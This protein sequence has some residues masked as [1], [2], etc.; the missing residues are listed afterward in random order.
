MCVHMYQ[1][2]IL[3]TAVSVEIGEMHGLADRGTLGGS[4]GEAVPTCAMALG[5]S[6]APVDRKTAIK[7]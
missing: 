4:E 5:S 1:S 3:V 2:P 7:I 6:E